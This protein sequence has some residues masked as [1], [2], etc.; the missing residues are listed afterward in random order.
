[1][2]IDEFIEVDVMDFSKVRLL[3]P[4]KGELGR[5]MDLGAMVYS[6]RQLNHKISQTDVHFPTLVNLKTFR[7]ERLFCISNFATELIGKRPSTIKTIMQVVFSIFDWMDLN[8]HVEFLM[9]EQHLHKAYLS[10]TSHLIERSKTENHENPLNPRGAKDKQWMLRKLINIAFPNQLEKVIGGIITLKGKANPQVPI[11]GSYLDEYWD[12]N[13]EIFLKFSAQ[14]Y[15]NK[16]FPPY[17][18]TTKINSIYLP[19]RQSDKALLLTPYNKNKAKVDCFC[20]QTGEYI[21][22][23]IRSFSNATQQANKWLDKLSE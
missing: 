10:Y 21:K 19:I 8:D 14:C 22:D 11:S 17:I 12:V 23:P 4:L 15:S 18:I 1:M 2:S 5:P 9:S 6:D 3:H 16:N 7:K 13:L 20:Y